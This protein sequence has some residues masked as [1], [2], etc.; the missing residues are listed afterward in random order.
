[1]NSLSERDLVLERL[2]VLEGWAEYIF[3]A[4]VLNCRSESATKE[5]MERAIEKPA[6][7]ELRE[8]SW[9]LR[10][11]LHLIV[12]RIELTRVEDVPL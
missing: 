2:Q 4:L 5:M 12:T 9:S 6:L 8:L 1:M 10:D 7:R 3:E 11:K